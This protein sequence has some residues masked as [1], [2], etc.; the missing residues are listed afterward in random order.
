L[1]GIPAYCQQCGS[2]FASA[3]QSPHT[4]TEPCPNC[5]TDAAPAVDALIL[6]TGVLA[7]ISAGRTSKEN[8]RAFSDLIEAVSCHNLPAEEFRSEAAELDPQFREILEQLDQESASP[9]ASLILVML[10]L[11]SCNYDLRISVDVYQVWQQISEDQVVAFTPSGRAVG[12]LL[13]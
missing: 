5:S 3:R 2:L 10:I 12:R 11:K 4:A 1:S 7:M 13:H 8:L 6:S 9:M